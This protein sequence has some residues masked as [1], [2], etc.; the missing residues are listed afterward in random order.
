M[1]SLYKS[2]N[3]A[4]TQLAEISKTNLCNTMAQTYTV[5]MAST[6]I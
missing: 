2:V 6:Q 4:H 3:F 1:H 5:R